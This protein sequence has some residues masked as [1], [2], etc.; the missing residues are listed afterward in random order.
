MAMVEGSD[1]SSDGGRPADSPSAAAEP[2]KRRRGRRPTEASLMVRGLVA[3]LDKT[4]LTEAQIAEYL[5][6]LGVPTPTGKEEWRTNNVRS[7]LDSI[8][9]DEESD[10]AAAEIEARAAEAVARAPEAVAL[11]AEAVAL[12]AE[13]EGRDEARPGSSVRGLWNFG[14][15]KAQLEETQVQLEE[16][17]KESGARKAQLEETQAQL[18]E[19]P[20]ATQGHPDATRRGWSTGG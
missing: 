13:A 8:R 9:R 16:S 19:S 2:R 3:E 1:L 18:E 17:R 7:I 12:A 15:R 6:G 11:A 5:T 4:E 14:A 20:G 10:E